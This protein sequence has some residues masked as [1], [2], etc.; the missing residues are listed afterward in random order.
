M[1]RT[2]II[3]DDEMLGEAKRITGE[4]KTSR[5]VNKAL[6]ML[7]RK[8]KLKEFAALRGSGI[9][10]ITDEELEEMRRNE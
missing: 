1:T 3:I 10:D 6:E 5:V 8:E 7:V 4:V 2:T 9:V